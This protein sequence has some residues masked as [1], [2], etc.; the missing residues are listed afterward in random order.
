[1]DQSMQLSSWLSDHFW[2]LCT[3]SCHPTLSLHH[4]HRPVSPASKL[5]QKKRFFS[6]IKINSHYELLFWKNFPVFLSFPIN[7]SPLIASDWPTFVP[8][9]G[10]YLHYK[11][12]LLPKY[13]IHDYRESY[14]TGNLT[15][16][17]CPIYT[18]SNT[19][20]TYTCKCV[21]ACEHTS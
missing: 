3:I 6:P 14:K 19:V 17:T 1:M 18:H 8:S 13:K 16:W 21:H 20:P 4:L 5:K 12:Y 11:S 7:V 2:R 10:R 9:V 15:H